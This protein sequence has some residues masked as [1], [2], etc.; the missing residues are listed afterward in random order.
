VKSNAPTR[1]VSDPA[2]A[3]IAS[4]LRAEREAR[5]AIE[6]TQLEAQHIAE[7]SRSSARALAE[8]T[9]RRIRSIVGAFEQQLSRQLADID[10][11]AA[12]MT[13]PHVLGEAELA[14]LHHAVRKLARQLIGAAP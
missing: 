5:D 13:T 10:A 14:A 8:R 12:R 1:A 11:E 6:H 3:A 2:E 4:V 7:Q 9:E